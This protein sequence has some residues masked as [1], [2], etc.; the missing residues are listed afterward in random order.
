MKVLW[1]SCQTEL[2]RSRQAWHALPLWSNHSHTNGFEWEVWSRKS[3]TWPC[4]CMARF[5][6]SCAINTSNSHELLSEMYIY[7][8]VSPVFRRLLHWLL[9]WKR[10]YN[11]LIL[12]NCF[13]YIFFWQDKILI[14]CCCCFS[15]AKLLLLS[16][17]INS[18]EFIG[19][20]FYLDIIVSL[21]LYGPH[22]RHYFCMGNIYSYLLTW[23]TWCRE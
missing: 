6:P 20:Y 16:L 7:M 4:K 23:T 11:S 12:W 15:P 1:S 13:I 19:F 3:H 10:F 14:V 17:S 8:H 22:F 21:N 18:H 2:S 5:S 9:R